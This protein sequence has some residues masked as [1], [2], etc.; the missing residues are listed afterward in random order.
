MWFEVVVHLVFGFLVTLT[1]T[2]EASLHKSLVKPG[3][4]LAI[5]RSY[6]INGNKKGKLEKQIKYDF[7]ITLDRQ[8][9]DIET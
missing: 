6:G 4:N 2:F 9:T 7:F 8:F 5:G 3:R 1:P